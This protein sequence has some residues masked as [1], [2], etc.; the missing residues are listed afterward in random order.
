M[1]FSRRPTSHLLIES[2]TLTIWPWNDLELPLPSLWPLPKTCKTKLN[3]C[4]GSQIS[5]YD[6]D[7]DPLTLILKQDLDNTMMYYYAKDEVSISIHSKVIAWTHMRTHIYTH[8]HTDATKTL[9]LLQ[10]A[11][12]NCGLGRK[13][14]SITAKLP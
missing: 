9:P 14:L 12:G 3:C 7:I 8:T 2:P 13:P 5:I 4:P 11:G 10:Y 6:L 1:P